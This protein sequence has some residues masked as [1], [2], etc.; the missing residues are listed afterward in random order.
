MNIRHNL[1][2][3]VLV[4][5]DQIIDFLKVKQLYI[6][7][8]YNDNIV[9]SVK[10][11][12]NAVEKSLCWI[13]YKK[14]DLNELESS[15]LIVS[16]R[17]EDIDTNKTIIKVKDLRLAVILV[18]N[19]FF[20]EENTPFISDNV[21]IDDNVILGKNCV[22]N[23]NVSIGENCKVGNNVFISNNVTILPN[24]IIGDNVFIDV[25]TVIGAEGQ[26]HIKDENN[27]YMQFPHISGVIVE[28]FVEIGANSVIVRG[29]LD[30]TKIGEFT[31]IGPLCVIGHNV[32]I[33]KNNMLAGNN[34]ISGSSI[35]GNNCWIGLSA[36]ISDGLKIGDNAK[37]SIGSVVMNN[38]S[39]DKTV[40]G[41][42]A[43]EHNNFL[44]NYLRLFK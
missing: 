2:K 21:C 31:K 40:T 28:D 11:L 7:D 34:S 38:I 23:N 5:S 13:S 14:F 39:A 44:I 27:N 42:L 20:I 41:Y 8:N 30:N 4:T 25:G 32:L 35:I 19:M 37:V 43:Q 17:F 1:K 12:S 15:I 22:I 16:E 24:S 9:K 3:D 33:G 10:A 6:S 26:G 36:T 18:I 29:V